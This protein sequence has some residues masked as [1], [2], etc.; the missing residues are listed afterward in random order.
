MN[1]PK[2]ITII[3]AKSH[4]RRIPQKNKKLLNG[5]PLFQYAIEQAQEAKICGDIFVATDDLEIKEKS[6]QLG[7][8]VPFTRDASDTDPVTS[9][10]EATYN[11]LLRI[12]NELKK[13]YDY[14]CL[15]LTTSPLR[16]AQD[17]VQTYQILKSNSH[18]DAATSLEEMHKHHYWSWS[19]S[20]K[21]PAQIQLNFPGKENLTK[22]EAGVSYFIDGAVYW[23]KVES[24]LNFKGNQYKGKL[25]GYIMPKERAI[26]IDNV[27]DFNF[28]EFL[29]KE[30]KII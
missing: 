27:I 16:Q 28:C 6:I 12:Q 15:L 14:L 13:N 26:D 23:A 8:K 20:Q 4:S 11:F 9:V 25:G 3:P 29:I 1:N 19:F 22:E 30:K 7:A 24:F 21:Q 2:V 10:G 17:I 18:L 5:K